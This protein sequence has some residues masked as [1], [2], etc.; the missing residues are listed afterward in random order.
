MAG[1]VSRDCKTVSKRESIES[2]AGGFMIAKRGARD[3]PGWDK[4]HEEFRPDET[5][6]S[7]WES[8]GLSSI[9]NGAGCR[10]SETGNL[11]RLFSF[12]PLELALAA[13]H[14]DAEYRICVSGFYRLAP[15]VRFCTSCDSPGR[16]RLLPGDQCHAQLNLTR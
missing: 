10:S 4:V 15:E 5:Q 13:P 1:A 3:N 11:G 8:A 12:L 16:Y 14:L 2:V 6:C 7:D 9:S